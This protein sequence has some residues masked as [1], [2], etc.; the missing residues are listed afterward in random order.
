MEE[1]TPEAG[2]PIDDFL[3]FFGKTWTLHI[4][5][6]LGQNGETRFAKL[7]REI[8]GNISARILSARLRSLEAA[9]FIERK[10]AGVFPLNVS[11][12]L[13]ADGLKLHG[14]MQRMEEGLRDARITARLKGCNGTGTMVQATMNASECRVACVRAP[15]SRV[16][17]TCDDVCEAP[18]RSGKRPATPM[19]PGKSGRS[20][21]FF[22]QA[23]SSFSKPA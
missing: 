20:G 8:P 14:I 3:R 1:K 21:Y 12:R 5:W 9:G 23:S 6:A 15:G 4:I 7:R 13:S 10:D 11:Y 16:M 22:S 17:I 2:C 18:L 19:L